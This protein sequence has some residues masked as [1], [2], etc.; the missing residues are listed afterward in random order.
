MICDKVDAFIL[1][2]SRNKKEE[3][4]SFFFIKNSVILEEIKAFQMN[5]NIVLFIVK[6][7]MVIRALDLPF[8]SCSKE[9]YSAECMF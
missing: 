3:G 2:I 5:L 7:L 8:M 9:Q 6:F 1:S 4:Q